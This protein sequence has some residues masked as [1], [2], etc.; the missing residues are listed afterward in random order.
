VM[1]NDISVNNIKILQHANIFIVHP[2]GIVNCLL[3]AGSKMYV[4]CDS[5]GTSDTGVA[6]TRGR[7]GSIPQRGYGIP[8]QWR[9]PAIVERHTLSDKVSEYNGIPL[10]AY[11]PSGRSGQT[12][13]V[14]R[15]WGDRSQASNTADNSSIS[16]GTAT[17]PRLRDLLDSSEMV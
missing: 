5:T 13:D 2:L 11:Q 9:S 3:S 1:G 14:I 4:H 15:S 8:P 16:V 7:A 17:N 10:M 6:Y 12:R